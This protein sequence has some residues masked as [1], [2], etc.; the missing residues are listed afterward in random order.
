MEKSTLKA[1]EQIAADAAIKWAKTGMGYF[2]ME[3]AANKYIDATGANRA[4]GNDPEAIRLGREAAAMRIDIES[5]HALTK[6]QEQRLNDAL[7][8]IARDGVPRQR[9][10][11]RR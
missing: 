11:F 10:S 1:L 8:K 3:D 6:D 9:R 7:M 2:A 4:I 5:I